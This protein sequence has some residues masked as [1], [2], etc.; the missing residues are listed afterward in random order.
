MPK[1][2]E[3]FRKKILDMEEMWQFPLNLNLNL[4]I[5]IP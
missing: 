4:L 1:S 2:E 3:D 5:D